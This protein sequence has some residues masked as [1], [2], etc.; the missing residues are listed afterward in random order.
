MKKII[1]A[2]LIL[3]IVVSMVCVS[4]SAAGIHVNMNFE[5][6]DV[7]TNQ[8]NAGQFYVDTPGELYG[9]SEA[10]ALQT[11]YTET[12]DGW[13]DNTGLTWLTYDAS[14]TVAA[15][16]DDLN[17]GSRWIN[18]VYCNDNL[19]YEGLEE[20]RV[21]MA[22]TYDIQNRCF[23]LA[24]GWNNDTEEEQYLPPVYMEINTDGDEFI[25]MG[26]SISKDRM[27]CF[28]NNQLIFDL[29]NP[30]LLIAHA[31]NSPFLFW[32]DGNFVRI[33]NITVADWGTLY[34]DIPVNDVTTPVV[35]NEPAPGPVV[36]TAAPVETTTS[37]KEVDVTN[38]KGETVTDA[39]GAKVTETVIITQAPAAE[40]NT[41]KPAGGNAS[42]TGDATFV[43][44]AAMVA[45]LGCALIVRKVNAD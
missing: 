15:G 42:A 40:T 4:T 25:T 21:Q 1:S 33:N 34:P 13:F 28:Y 30:D 7:F 9:Y 17:D 22:F 11:L 36:T 35:T 45:T 44:I 24:P 5:S 26:I 31:I 32:Q 8:F 39:S 20:D 16:D 43:V 10:K 3:T 19:M 38:E 18:L 37:I 41:N 14:I 23:R 12:E 27:R 2:L 29:Q 6:M